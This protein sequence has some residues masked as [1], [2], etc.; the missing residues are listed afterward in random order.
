MLL[1]IRDL[2]VRYGAIHAMRGV[3]LAVEQGEIVA[4]LGPNGAGKSSILNACLGLAPRSGG[5]IAFN[6]API[7][8][9]P[10]EII[11]RRG[12]T[13][14]PEGRRVFPRLT[15]LE[16]LKIGA[17]AEAKLRQAS[18][19]RVEEMLALFPALADRRQQLAGTLSGGEQ[20]MLAIARSL[21]SAPQ[22][23]LLDEPSLGLAPNIV[24]QI[25]DLIVELKRRGVTIL[26]VEQ[27]VEL[28]LAIA[29]RGYLLASGRIALG[30]TTSELKSTGRLE[31]AYL[32]VA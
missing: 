23:L 12:L 6:G 26:L 30:G 7:V 10:T 5:S 18:A 11:V 17:A 13:L 20:Q 19:G 22:A 31:R 16:N 27:N 3:S 24:D 4:L 2:D 14:T 21:M 29:D 32:G 9:L 8:R 1:E 25:F 15:V 28:S